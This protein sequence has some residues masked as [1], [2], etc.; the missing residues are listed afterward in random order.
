MKKIAIIYNTSYYLYLFRKN[1]VKE[2]LKQGFE[3]HCIAMEDA[4]TPPL[5]ALGCVFTDVSVGS[6]SQ[7]PLQDLKYCNSLYKVLKKIKPDLVLNYTAKP[8]IYGT[9]AAKLAGIPTINNIGGLGIGFTHQN[10]VTK[11]LM[12]LY[13]ISQR[14]SDVVFFQNPD[15]MEMFLKNKMV[16]PAHAHLLPGSGVDLTH[17]AFKPLIKKDKIVFVLLARMLYSKG[18]VLML[19]A[20]KELIEKGFSNFELRL[21]GEFGVR[22]KDCI[23]QS[24]REKWQAFSHVHF[25]DKVDEVRPFLE[26]AD[27]MVLPSYYR[28]GTPRSVLEALAVGRPII[29]SNMPGCK[30]TVVPGYNGYICEPREVQ[31][32]AEAME[33]ILKAS[34]DNLEIMGKNSR[35]LAE[36]KFDEKIIFDAYKKQ[37]TLLLSK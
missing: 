3:V 24:E 34:F 27:C 19:E 6:N 10:L 14:R 25:I 2:L 20:S 33:K 37:I 35:K 1:L 16:L 7:N 30:E 11:V 13:K 21:V 28:E 8:L 29:T 5:K 36:D 15:D 31:S 9:L 17:F 23:P 4:Y 22:N 32:L 26:E 12:F 18:V